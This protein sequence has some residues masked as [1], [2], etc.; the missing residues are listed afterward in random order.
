MKILFVTPFAGLTGSEMMLRYLVNSLKE[1]TDWQ[2]I[3]GANKPGQ[4]LKDFNCPTFSIPFADGVPVTIPQRLKNKW[5]IKTTGLT[6]GE[7]WWKS[8]LKKINPD[9][10]YFNTIHIHNW[11]FF[12]KN[13]DRPFVVHV[14]EMAFAYAHIIGFERMK[15]M[16][17]K[18]SLLIAC[19]EVVKDML[20]QMGLTK[21][22]LIHEA[23]DP[24][25]I[26]ISEGSRSKV[27]AK[28]GIPES[29]FVWIMAGT[30]DFRK[31]LDFVAPIMARLPKR[32]VHLV[33]MGA[34]SQRN[35]LDYY[36]QKQME[37]YG[38]TNIHFPGQIKEEYYDYFS[39]GDGFI[40]PSREDPFPLV[41][42]EAAFLGLPIIGF[43]SGGIAEFVQEGMGKVIE[44]FEVE[45]MAAAM[46]QV[47]DGTYK[48]NPHKLKERAKEF[49]IE[50]Q[51]AKWLIALKKHLKK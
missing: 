16:M 5:L 38:L 32:G 28:L 9:V 1:T 44:G 35:G 6:I 51:S 17:E 47:M 48:P 21:I 45:K 20:E 15:L 10:V 41:M 23:L 39:A 31:G 4:L 29:D 46:Y 27:R 26:Q 22:A 14:H 24:K 33:W 43:N 3:V 7:T 30:A 19:S 34:K 2:A 50:G 36:A 8:Q 40:L 25:R 11:D 12:L 18:A 49:L 37:F 13:P 42:I